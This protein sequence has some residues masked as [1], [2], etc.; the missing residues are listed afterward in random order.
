M[1]LGFRQ[2]PRAESDLIDLWRFIAAD[3]ARAA[4]NLVRRLIEQSRVLCASPLIGKARPDIGPGIRQRPVGEYRILYR[5]TAK[6]V[7]VGRYIHGRRDLT[8][9]KF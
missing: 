9:I 3:S 6:Y 8:R 4:D 1:T 7:E 2:R 5:M